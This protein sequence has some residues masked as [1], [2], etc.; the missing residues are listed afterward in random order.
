MVSVQAIFALDYRYL[1]DELTQK[2]QLSCTE[3]GRTAT[4][5]Y[6]SGSGM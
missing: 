1:Q 5:D 6:R 3:T 4:R 2:T